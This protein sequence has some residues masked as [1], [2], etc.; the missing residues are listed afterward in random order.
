MVVYEDD[1]QCS[2]VQWK[3]ADRVP[4]TD[5]ECRI[6]LLDSTIRQV[7]LTASRKLCSLELLLEDL[8]RGWYRWYSDRGPTLSMQTN[9]CHSEGAHL[10]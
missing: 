6:G 9:N 8:V 4:E 3:M 10:P 5:V 1:M 7:Q 2:K